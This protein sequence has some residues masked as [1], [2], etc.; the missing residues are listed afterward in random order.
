MIRRTRIR[1][2][3][4]ERQLLAPSADPEEA[5]DRTSLDRDPDPLLGGPRRGT[6]LVRAVQGPSSTLLRRSRGER[7]RDWFDRQARNS[8]A[9]LTLAV[10]FGIIV[11]I[12]ILLCLPV[13]AAG[14]HRVPFVDVVFTAVSAVCVT[15][16][17]TVDT[18]TSWS[19]F[20]QVVIALGISVG[21]L[22]LMTL[23]SILGFAVSRHLG[24][25]QRML[26][27]QETGSTGLGQVGTLLRAVI[28]TSLVAEGVL[29]VVFLPVFLDLRETL[30]E[31]VW[32]S[33]FMAVSVFNNA[34]FVITSEGMA[35]HVNDWGILLPIALGT[36]VGAIGFPVITDVASRWRTPRR[37][38][39][40]TKL[41]L[42][43][44]TM[45]TVIGSVMLALT[46]WTNPETLGGL[47]LG[48]K[49]LNSLLA[50]VNTRSSG[51]SALDVGAM[52]SQT[53]FVQ[54]I[55][56]MI[57]G[58]SASTAG[59]IKVSTF[60]VLMLAVVAEAR[61]DRD[62]E[63]FGRRIPT[64]V[65]R[66]AVAVSLIGMTMV[67]VSV[68]LLLSM[69]DFS[70]DVVLFEAISA[71]ATV[72]LT[73]G[74]TSLLPDAAKCVLIVLMFAGRTGTMTVA[75]AL[76]LRQRRRVI[77]LPAERPVIG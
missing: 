23:A 75:A 63:A 3:R 76:A 73:T 66:L 77:R 5:V 38:T 52:Q 59:G 43:T 69:T 47:D 37:W 19:L 54:D 65:V 60:A 7:L 26:A 49:V 32:H 71:F 57:G 70:L 17:T 25:T 72:G 4:R 51:L 21:G 15:G 29:F 55:L 44:Y 56:M 42:A 68:L 6:P 62:I 45:L 50:G 28:A 74:I 41:T 34:G 1:R 61:G 39:L 12:T 18:A 13:S 10:F 67:G 53:H 9:R 8:P 24:L 33:F 22:G 58:G 48:S 27:A 31:A 46:E 2:R 14:S 36:F 16:L 35:P 20:G 40:H 64:T 11:L 30:S